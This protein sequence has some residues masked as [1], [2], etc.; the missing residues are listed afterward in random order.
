[1]HN[2]V[3]KIF[4]LGKIWKKSPKAYWTLR[5][6][7]WSPIWPTPNHFG[8]SWQFRKPLILDNPRPDSSF[9]NFPKIKRPYRA[10]QIS[11]R[12]CRFS[13]TVCVVLLFVPAGKTLILIWWIFLLPYLSFNFMI[14]FA[15]VQNTAIR[16][17]RH[18]VLIQ[19]SFAV[20]RTRQIGFMHSKT[21]NKL[22]WFISSPENDSMISPQLFP[23]S[24]RP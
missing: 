21:V 10:L 19:F 12:G 7:W 22:N 5:I 9:T 4:S 23:I 3:K 15:F 11:L 14:S 13:L 2:S 16:K 8:D 20:T 6:P 18:P 17:T 1:M 24:K